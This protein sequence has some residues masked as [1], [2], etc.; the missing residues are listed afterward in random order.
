MFAGAGAGWLM[1]EL[2]I[3]LAL[4]WYCRA[5]VDVAP[6]VITASYLW[7]RDLAREADRQ[8]SLADNDSNIFTAATVPGLQPATISTFYFSL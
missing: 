5:G 3:C 8:I 7:S 4:L 1:T 6:I 2:T